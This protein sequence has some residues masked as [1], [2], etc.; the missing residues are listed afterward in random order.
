M[1]AKEKGTRFFILTM[2]GAFIL[3][4]LG[5]SALVIWTIA[6]GDSQSSQQ[7][8]DLQKQLQDQLK[9]QQCSIQPVNGQKAEPLPE[10]AVKT[11]GD[12]TKLQKIDLKQG[13]GKTAK[14]GDCLVVKYNGTLAKNGKKFDGDFDKD[15]ALQFALGQGKVIKGWDEGLVGMK[16]GGIRK[17]I[18]PSDMAYGK[19]SSAQIPADSDLI[20]VVK[21]LAIK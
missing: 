19:R 17:L 21:L 2:V 18:I 14:A 8:A 12:V 10:T 13:T 5:F 16:V 3:S 15:Q 11:S 4:S 6:K 7:T 9:Q 20:F 1:S